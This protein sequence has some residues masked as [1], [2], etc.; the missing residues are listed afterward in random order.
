M[1]EKHT[2]ETGCSEPQKKVLHTSIGYNMTHYATE[3]KQK[4]ADKITSAKGK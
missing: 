2:N 4:Q 3:E 1:P